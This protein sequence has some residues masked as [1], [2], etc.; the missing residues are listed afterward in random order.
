MTAII[1]AAIVCLL[2]I[3]CLLILYGVWLAAFSTKKHKEKKPFDLPAA[4]QYRPFDDAMI[5]LITDALAVPFEEVHTESFDGLDLY[6]RLYPGKPGNV[7]QIQMHGWKSNGVRDFA[8]G[9]AIARSAGQTVLLPDERGINKSGGGFLTYGILERKD[10]L[11]WISYINK[12]FNNPPIILSGLSMG[13]ASV[14][15][16]LDQQLPPNVIGVIADSAYSSPREIISHV[17]AERGLPAGISWKMARASARLFGHFNIEETD[18]VRAI[19]GSSLPVLLIHGDDDHFVPVQMS[20][21]IYE[22][23]PCGTRLEIF[24]GAPHGIS[25]LLGRE[26]YRQAE[27]DFIDHCLEE[28]GKK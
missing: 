26:R 5:R 15:M 12:R 28:A 13:A 18:A 21:K 22:A 3:L 8:G 19:A 9:S 16:A 10:I 23:R 1:L 11:S 6:G 17:A 25:Y 4:D 20:R 2:L 24:H 7:V 14:I 27:E